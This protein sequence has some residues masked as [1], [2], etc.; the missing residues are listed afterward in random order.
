MQKALQLVWVVLFKM[1]HPWI[2]LDCELYQKRK[3]HYL[4]CQLS[5]SQWSGII[6]TWIAFFGDSVLS[7]RYFNMLF[8]IWIMNLHGLFSLIVKTK[9]LQLLDLHKLQLLVKDRL[10]LTNSNWCYVSSLISSVVLRAKK[11]ISQFII[12]AANRIFLT[13]ASL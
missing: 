3:F 12:K 5:T 9:E 10:T 13:L 6:P 7:P 4:E 11:R 2:T 1:W 8:D